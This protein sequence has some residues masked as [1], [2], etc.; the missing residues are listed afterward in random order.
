MGP[1]GCLGFIGD[2]IL[3]TYVE[4]MMSHYKDTAY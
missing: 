1:N 3:S 4:I 2:D